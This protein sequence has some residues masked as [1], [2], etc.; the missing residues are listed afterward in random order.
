MNRIFGIKLENFNLN[1]ILFVGS[2]FETHKWLT[3]TYDS[4]LL[5]VKP[6]LLK[7]DSFDT[8]GMF[9]PISRIVQHYF[10]VCM[11]RLEGILS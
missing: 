3:R 10:H 7:K 4:F 8:F 2:R 6:F 9:L 5:H 1:Q 11:C